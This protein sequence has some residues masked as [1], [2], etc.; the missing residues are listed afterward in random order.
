MYANDDHEPPH[1]CHLPKND[2]ERNLECR[3]HKLSKGDRINPANHVH[4]DDRCFQEV[5]LAKEVRK[6]NEPHPPLR[7]N[8]VRLLSPRGFTEDVYR[9]DLESALESLTEHHDIFTSERDWIAHI[10]WKRDRALLDLPCPP[11]K[12]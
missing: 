9:A 1:A 11:A 7:R 4:D 8:Y 3:R 6:W 10:Q 2:V 12:N 5:R